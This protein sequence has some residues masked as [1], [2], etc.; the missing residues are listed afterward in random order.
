MNILIASPLDN[1]AIGQMCL[2][3]SETSEKLNLI[4]KNE[5]A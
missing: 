5:S 3:A 2:K 1:I 4:W